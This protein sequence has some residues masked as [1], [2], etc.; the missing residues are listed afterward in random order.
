[1]IDR[2]MTVLALIITLIIMF[3]GLAGTIIPML[4]GIPLIYLGYLI[5]GLATGW[6]HYGAQAMVGWGAV[7]VL[8]VGIDYYAGA[9]GAK[10]FGATRAGVIGSLIGGL[11]GVIFLG[12][13]GLIAGPFLGAVA[14]ELLGGAPQKQAMRAGWGT[15]VG[16]LAGSLFKVALALVMI[17][18]FLWW[19]IF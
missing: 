16:F 19:I 8:S 18:T 3:V 4:P 2:D 1:M 7:A 14:G 17:G 13:L 9:A 15:F 11:V 12:L 5:Y 6:S 10:K